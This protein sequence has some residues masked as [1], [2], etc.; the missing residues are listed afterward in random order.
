[1]FGSRRTR[2]THTTHAST[3]GR[4]IGGMFHRV[5]PNRRAGGYKAAL[6]NPNTTTAGRQHAKRG[7]RTMGRGREAHVPLS[8]RIKHFLHLGGRRRHTTTTHY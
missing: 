7:L 3:R 1:M 5:N 6:H 8:V 2:V 4:G